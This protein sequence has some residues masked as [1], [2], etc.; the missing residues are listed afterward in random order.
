[1]IVG[2]FTNKAKFTEKEES[3]ACSSSSES[4]KLGCSVLFNYAADNGRVTL[5][6]SPGHAG[7][8]ILTRK[9]AASLESL[10]MS[11][12]AAVLSNSKCNCSKGK[13]D[14][15]A[16]QLVQRKLFSAFQ[17]APSPQLLCKHTPN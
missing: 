1:M 3:A 14:I 16:F 12:Q 8:F 5:T 11:M 9:V 15:S 13:V 2:A 10:Q 6:K 17:I 4:A 7:D